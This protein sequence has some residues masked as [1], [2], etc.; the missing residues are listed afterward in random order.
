MELLLK[1]YL[2]ASTLLVVCEIDLCYI[3]I[4]N[5]KIDIRH[6]LPWAQVKYQFNWLMLTQISFKIILIR[7]CI[8]FENAPEFKKV[9][10][11]K[12]KHSLQCTH[13]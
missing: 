10:I 6:F 7:Q 2:N 13:I 1:M 12:S 3:T 4:R 5:F 8:D 9:R 11:L